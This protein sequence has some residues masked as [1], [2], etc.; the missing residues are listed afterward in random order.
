MRYN[1]L[2]I[3]SYVIFTFVL[4][5]A[6]S[7]NGQVTGLSVNHAGLAFSMTSGDTI[8]WSYDI[9]SGTTTTGE[10]WL[11]V[12]TNGTIEP[13]TD[14]FVVS[15]TQTDGDTNGNGGPP[16]FDR[17]V[18][19]HVSF[20][21]RIGFFAGHYI[22]KFTNNGGSQNAVGTIS[23]LASPAH[24]LSGTVTPPPAKSAKNLILQL[25][26]KNF[27]QEQ[28][29]WTGITDTAGLYTISLNADTAGPWNL[30]FF[31]NP[32]P[33]A[34]Q[35]PADTEF[36][37]VG[38]PSGLDFAFTAPAAQ[39]TGYLMDENNHPIPSQGVGLSRNDYSI[40]HDGQTDISGFFNIGLL[41]SELNG[42]TWSL[43]A[44]CNCPNGTNT[45]QLLNNINLPVI[46]I[47]DSLF[48]ILVVYSVNSQITGQVTLNGS[49]V[50]FPV[51]VNAYSD[52][53]Q[54]RSEV[55]TA[56]GNFILYDEYY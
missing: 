38:N 44:D 34:V 11:D 12:N 49:P 3:A 17:T 18:D 21:Q 48:R 27:N 15:F 43:Q 53:G 54:A 52:S 56:T 37:I 33:G 39:V 14:V 10:I 30:R 45:S 26:R 28:I 35:T 5:F 46:N 9:P 1:S 42:Q 22:M 6:N 7:T 4:F 23:P 31:N 13:G 47:G 25:E 55:D 50:N 16:D 20:Y 24:T 41:A 36:Y 29:F 51:Y 19:G 2:R 32:F 8:F 40:R